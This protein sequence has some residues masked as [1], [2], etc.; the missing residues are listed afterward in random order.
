MEELHDWEVQNGSTEWRDNIF[1]L[2]KYQNK[3]IS[4]V[5]EYWVR[6]D[7]NKIFVYLA[8]DKSVEILIPGTR[9]R[10]APDLPP[11]K[12]RQHLHP[13]LRIN[14]PWFH[15]QTNTC[16]KRSLE[17]FRRPTDW[18]GIICSIPCIKSSKRLFSTID[19]DMVASKPCSWNFLWHPYNW[20]KL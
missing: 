10:A 12:V 8:C 20:Y 3:G 14:Q 2:T 13:Y 15:L 9:R 1:P 16:R 19:S 7:K 6:T 17:T 18:D 4:I 11:V 5:T